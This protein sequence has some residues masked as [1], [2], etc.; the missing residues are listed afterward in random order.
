MKGVGDCSWLLHVNI[1][2][3]IRAAEAIFF[4][5]ELLP[6][7]Q[8]V[9]LKLMGEMPTY[10]T[11]CLTKVWGYFLRARRRD[12]GSADDLV[13]IWYRTDDLIAFGLIRMAAERPQLLSEMTDFPNSNQQIIHQA[14][15]ESLVKYKSKFGIQASTRTVTTAPRLRIVFDEQLQI[16]HCSI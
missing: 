14:G 11:P 8:W 5:A 13:T 4:C 9:K 3:W 16:F 6:H 2:F 7:F 12:G 10:R 1:Q 15:S